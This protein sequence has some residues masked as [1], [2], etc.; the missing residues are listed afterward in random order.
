MGTARAQ[1]DSN[2]LSA[3][4]AVEHSSILLEHDKDSDVVSARCLKRGNQAELRRFTGCKSF[5]YCSK[6]C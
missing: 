6:D 1:L 3:E 2:R 5:S 4:A